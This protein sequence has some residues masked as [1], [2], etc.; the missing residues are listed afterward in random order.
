MCAVAGNN[1]ECC[2]GVGSFRGVCVRQPTGGE[3][4]RRGSRLLSGSSGLA[5][6]EVGAVACLTNSATVISVPSEVR[7]LL[8]V[9]VP[10]SL[11]RVRAGSSP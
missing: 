11:T 10:P 9:S 7:T 5:G 4:K 8:T 1:A 6:Y 2:Q 3:G